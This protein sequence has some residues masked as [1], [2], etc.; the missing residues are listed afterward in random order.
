M[1]ERKIILYRDDFNPDIFFSS[2]VEEDEEDLIPDRDIKDCLGYT[3]LRTVVDGM[4]V[5]G[6]V[7]TDYIREKGEIRQIEPLKIIPNS[8][9]PRPE[10]VERPIQV[11]WE[12]ESYLDEV[13]YEVALEHSKKRAERLGVSF[14]DETRRER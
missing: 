7:D 12:R 5:V 4:W 13:V 3:H 2:L 9:I 8:E 14:I 1:G 6:R 10:E 11:V